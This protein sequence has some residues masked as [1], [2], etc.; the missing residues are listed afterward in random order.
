MTEFVLVEYGDLEGGGFVPHVDEGSPEPPPTFAAAA[1]KLVR[2]NVPQ[3][4][5]PVDDGHHHPMWSL[6]QVDVEDVPHWCFA[7]QGRGGEFGQAGMCQF[8]FAGADFPPHLLWS[9][10]SACVRPDGRLAH[11]DVVGIADAWRRPVPWDA[12]SAGLRGL[13]SCDT[14]IVL[15]GSAV[16]VA[17]TIGALLAVL[18]KDVAARHVWSTYLVRRPVQDPRPIVTGRWP[19]ELPGGNA[20]LRSWLDR[21]P[22]RAGSPV[23]HP[24]A[25]AVV[26]WL[27]GLATKGT[28]LPPDYAAQ[29]GLEALSALVAAEQLD[30]HR[31]DVPRL[32]DAGDDRLTFGRGRDLLAEWTADSP[33]EAIVRLV[34][35][36]PEALEHVVFD[37]V[38]DVHQRAA[39][40]TNPALFPPAAS[41]VPGWD[42]KLAE[43]L[44]A[45][46]D[47]HE[48]MV[49]FVRDHVIAPGRP[50]DG[51]VH[52]HEE[53]LDLLG[54]P[55]SDPASVIY[56]VPTDRIVAEIRDTG[57]L[58]PDSLAFLDAAPAPIAEVRLVVDGLTGVPPQAAAGFVTLCTDDRQASDLLKYVLD[59]TT[60]KSVVSSVEKWLLDVHGLVEAK[61]R[62]VVLSE[63]LAHLLGRG[64]KLP[65][66]LLVLA[67]Q[68]FAEGVDL[69]EPVRRE[70]FAQTAAELEAGA[71]K[72]TTVGG[73]APA[74]RSRQSK[75][76]A[77]PL[78][79]TPSPVPRTPTPSTP[80]TAP[81]RT[82][83]V[84]H[85]AF[86]DDSPFAD[87]NPSADGSWFGDHGSSSEGTPFVDDGSSADHDSTSRHSR[88]RERDVE[89]VVGKRRR[90]PDLSAHWPLIGRLLVVVLAL[91]L[92]TAVYFLTRHMLER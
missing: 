89:P 15:P 21:A 4:P 45:R 83:V 14:K 29:P 66:S 30:F 54:V 71:K 13:F 84:D 68:T 8:L 70:V 44:C 50:L 82:P 65:V 76:K 5:E 32:L 51:L 80:Q 75:P 67:Q 64:G 69:A 26:D 57:A 87:R 60:G 34:R 38:L 42:L 72:S 63:G 11:P 17:A 23:G 90:L 37:T 7:V 18:P 9:R 74:H 59:R 91:A 92:L 73:T 33:V 39:P 2:G 52:R 12:L 31:A 78:R 41:R 35:G 48:Q 47:R 85:G 20:G 27:V 53:W 86:V 28:A 6:R 56:G 61:R 77:T 81:L 49:E 1:A 79:H 43:L 40:G 36:L 10:A 25:S 58:S 19:Q 88:P 3:P 24:Q 16:D 22:E 46:L 55:P 62:P